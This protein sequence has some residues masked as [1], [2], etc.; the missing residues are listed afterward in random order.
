MV[1]LPTEIGA[2]YKE[3]SDRKV[4]SLVVSVVVKPMAIARQAHGGSADRDGCRVQ[5][6][7]RQE[8]AVTCSQCR[9]K[10]YGNS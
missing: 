2:A 5:G 3:H 10:A 8:G 1:G 4:L 9:N 7:L 6:A